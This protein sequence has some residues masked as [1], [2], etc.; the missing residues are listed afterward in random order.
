MKNMTSNEQQ[1]IYKLMIDIHPIINGED[2]IEISLIPF[3]FF[4][5]STFL[6][7]VCDRRHSR[8]HTLSYLSVNYTALLLIDLKSGLCWD[9]MLDT[10]TCWLEGVENV[11]NSELFSLYNARRIQVSDPDSEKSGL[12]T[13]SKF[14]S[15]LNIESKY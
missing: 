8:E 7:Q 1:S 4:L 13:V 3:S 9:T 10:Y 14:S 5:S 11:A 6:E 15:Q 12:F 2:Y